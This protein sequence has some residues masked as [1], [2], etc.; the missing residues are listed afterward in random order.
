MLT[1]LVTELDGSVKTVPL[2]ESE[3]AI[4]EQQEKEW[5]DGLPAMQLQELRQNRNQL[6]TECD[7]TQV[8]DSPLSNE[9]KTEWAEYREKLRQLPQTEKDVSNPTWPSKPS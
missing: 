3:I 1:K 4:R 7:W 8:A 5:L 2:N 9:K 6:L